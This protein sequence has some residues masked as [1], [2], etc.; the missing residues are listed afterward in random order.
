MR[1]PRRATF[2]ALAILLVPG[3][4]SAAGGG[5]FTDAEQKG[6]LYLYLAAFGAG[7][8][9]SLTP[10]VYPMIP[11]TL[12]IFGARGKDVAKR[13]SMAL[14][15]SYVL[16]MSLTYAV[17]GVVFATIFGATGFGK[18]LAHPAVV[19]PLVILFVAFAASMF[20]AFEMNLPSGVQARLNQIGGKGFKGAFLMGSVGGLIAAPC[21]GPF[22]GG[23]LAF[24]A[25][26]SVI[27]GGTML[28]VYGLG[29]GI[30]F[31]VLAA[32]ASALPKSGAWMDTIKSVSGVL[33][34]LA[35]IYFLRPLLPWMR[36]FASPEIWFLLTAAAL[37]VVGIAM[38]AFHLTFSSSNAHRA[39]KAI[40]LLLVLAGL[41]GMWTWKLTPKH[42]LPWV[43]DEKTAFERARV[44]KKGVMVD[45]S[46]TWC[47][48]CE[49]LELTFGDSEVYEA[50]LASFVPLKIDVTTQT[51]INADQERR[52]KRDT[53]PHVVFV[54]PD[55]TELGRIKQLVEP[56]AMLE[57]IEPASRALRG[58]SASK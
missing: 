8:L 54:A 21:T 46:A 7:F 50:I 17:L 51:D 31:F 57:V 42:K 5:D 25:T 2:I 3:I 58:T 49:E 20:G 12:A 23:L 38:G 44:E 6:W 40:G 43:T 52:F 22:L 34:L 14:A 37:V 1:V 15:A 18:Q 24:T 35:A 27:G 53:F 9:T 36:T 10:C 48:P 30:L 29:M 47:I 28:F 26:T 32:F 11:I 16:G 4:A 13:R 19:I 39:R 45:F 56:D 41:F 55:G 33:M